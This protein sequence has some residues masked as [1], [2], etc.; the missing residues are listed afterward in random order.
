MENLKIVYAGTFLLVLIVLMISFASAGVGD[1]FRQITGRATANA[2]ANVTLTGDNEVIIYIWNSTLTGTVVDPN[3][4]SYLTIR[5]N[6]TVTDLD[7]S[8]DINTTSIRSN[9]TRAGEPLR[10][11]NTCE[12]GPTFGDSINFTCAID[13][14]YFDEPGVWNISVSATDFG[15]GT[16]VLNDSTQFTYGTLNEVVASLSL[17]SFG[18]VSQGEVNQSSSND[19]LILN[20]TGNVDFTNISINASDLIGETTPSDYIAVANLSVSN[21]TSGSDGSAR[22]ECLT[23]TL[24]GVTASTLINRTNYVQVINTTL[25]RGNLSL[26]DGTAQEDIYFCIRTVPT[27]IVSQAYSTAAS[28]NWVVNTA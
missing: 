7:G 16:I 24:N 10:E 8:A 3:S 27:G 9:F 11:N 14:W 12:E 26:N 17:I 4:G 19:P 21:S 23:T 2:D 6:V 18:S 25:S 13:M 1:W 22:D 15:T 5:F 20:N 28:G